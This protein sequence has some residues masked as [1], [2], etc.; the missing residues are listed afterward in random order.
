VE[1]SNLSIAKVFFK[2]FIGILLLVCVASIPSSSLFAKPNLSEHRMEKSSLK[3]PPH[4][5]AKSNITS[6]DYLQDCQGF[7]ADFDG[8]GGCGPA[9]DLNDE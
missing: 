7:Q 9:M 1:K 4:S 6:K 3:R 2:K 5:K 8:A